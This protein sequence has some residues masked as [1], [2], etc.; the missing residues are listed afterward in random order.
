MTPYF[1][2][3][4]ENLQTITNLDPPVSSQGA[5]QTDDLEQL[6]GTDFKQE[7]LRPQNSSLLLG[8]TELPVPGTFSF[9]YLAVF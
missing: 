3:Y 6:P 5:Y 1:N 8:N 9:L 2:I 7:K 4:K